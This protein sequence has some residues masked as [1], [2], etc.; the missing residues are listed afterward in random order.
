M[1]EA[2]QEEQAPAV[3]EQEQAPAAEEEEEVPFYR[4]VAKTR[5][6]GEPGGVP[7]QLRGMLQRLGVAH[8]PEFVI[9][10]VPRPGRDTYTARVDI[11]DLQ[12]LLSTHYNPTPWLTED[13][14]VSDAAW[15]AVTYYSYVYRHRLTGSVYALFPRRRRGRGDYTLA[16]LPAEV[17]RRDT[18]YSQD[19][20][21]N[22]S[23][24]LQSALGEI[25]A[26]EEMLRNTEATLRARL[27]M[28]QGEDS[29]LYSSEACTWIATSP[30]R[31][32]PEYQIVESHP[33]G[34]TP[35]LSSSSAASSRSR[36]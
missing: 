25:R 23:D 36:S 19:M 14:A 4:R 24:R 29:D 33:S 1:G 17:P 32:R 9:K 3:E 34:H 2:P 10:R 22:L 27:R 18:I 5:K 7:G 28:Q 13:G 12:H 6:L 15:E 21:L 26:L 35:P 31:G 8:A 20:A 11:Y 16:P 30:D